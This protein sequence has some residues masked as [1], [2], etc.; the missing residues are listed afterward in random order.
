MRA[1]IAIM[2]LVFVYFTVVQFNDPDPLLWI[3]LY[4]AVVAV[5][6]LA[7]FQRGGPVPIVGAIAYFGGAIYLWP[8]LEGQPWIDVEE[9]RESLGLAVAG[10]WMAV[11]AFSWYRRR[12]IATSEE[13]QDA[14][15]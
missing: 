12:R 11:L 8:D 1:V 5:S 15:T 7:F 9:A 6:V 10:C 3:G 4:G 2:V 14:P 13:G